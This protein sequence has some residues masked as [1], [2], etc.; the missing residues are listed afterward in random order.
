MEFFF[1]LSAT[2]TCISH[3]VYM[4]VCSGL[5]FMHE[6]IFG[7]TPMWGGIYIYL[8]LF[9]EICRRWTH[10][11]NVR[12]ALTPLAVQSISLMYLT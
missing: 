7:V 8:M 5:I 9:D 3:Y 10:C 6:E 2:S 1:Q 4:Q 11:V 12:A